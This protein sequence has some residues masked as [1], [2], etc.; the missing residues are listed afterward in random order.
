MSFVKKESLKL[1]FLSKTY[2]TN[3]LLSKI[4]FKFYCQKYLKNSF[5]YQN[6]LIGSSLDRQLMKKINEITH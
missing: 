1:R 5:L 2:F 4:P 3:F 6:K